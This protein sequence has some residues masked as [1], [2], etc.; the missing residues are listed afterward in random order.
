[1]TPGELKLELEEQT[2]SGHDFVRFKAD[3]RPAIA[4]VDRATRFT[5]DTPIR[6]RVANPA[7]RTRASSAA[8]STT[9]LGT[10]TVVRD[11]R[12][13]QGVTIGC[14]DVS[15]NG[16]DVVH[17]PCLGSHFPFRG[18]SCETARKRA[19]ASGNRERHRKHPC[20]GRIRFH[21]FENTNQRFRCHV[22]VPRQP[23]AIRQHVACVGY[24]PGAEDLADRRSDHR[25]PSSAF[26]RTDSD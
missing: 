25:R 26:P 1:M 9:L 13:H 15:G 14:L 12:K 10:L 2:A 3:Y 4:A 8:A 20:M 5:T 21:S 6:H 19:V 17:G 16:P 7:R 18:S 23:R 11:D 22:V 24:S